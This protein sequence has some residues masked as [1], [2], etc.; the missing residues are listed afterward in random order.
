MTLAS[1]ADLASDVPER[2][3]VH[4]PAAGSEILALSSSLADAFGRLR[5]PRLF[6][7]LVPGVN[8]TDYSAL[9]P[10]ATLDP[11]LLPSELRDGF[12]AGRVRTLALTYYGAARMIAEGSPYDLA[13]A[14]VAPPD[15]AG[16]CSLS[17]TA[18]F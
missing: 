2:A 4:L 15:A 1:L 13:F 17:L 18:D 11:L 12:A 3:R 6:A 14:H 5:A 10:G 9:A 7:G 8:R 16:N